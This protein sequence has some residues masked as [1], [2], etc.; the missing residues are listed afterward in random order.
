MWS[1]ERTLWGIR[2]FVLT[3][4]S[5][6]IVFSLYHFSKDKIT[7]AIENFVELIEVFLLF[8]LCIFL[9]PKIASNPKPTVPICM[10]ISTFF[11]FEC[12]L[13]HHKFLHTVR[14]DAHF[15]IRA[16]PE[17]AIGPT[18]LYFMLAPW[19]LPLPIRATRFTRHYI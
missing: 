8:R 16:H 5:T 18:Q 4:A 13:V 2:V 11:Y 9:M 3:R 7:I 12:W 6:F 19:K 1:R 15:T 14:E 10:V 17:L